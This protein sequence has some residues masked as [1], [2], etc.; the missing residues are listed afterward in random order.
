MQR[1]RPTFAGDEDH[2]ATKRAK[3]PAFSP[4]RAGCHPDGT[5]FKSAGRLLAI[6]AQHYVSK[7]YMNESERRIL[8]SI[9]DLTRRIDNV[10]HINRE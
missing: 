2:T 8:D 9:R 5:E 4:A 7:E 1:R 10:L 3:G 6:P